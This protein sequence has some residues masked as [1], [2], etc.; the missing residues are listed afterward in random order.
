MK[1]QLKTFGPAFILLAGFSWGIFPAFSRYLY[2]VGVDA[3]TVA[4]MRTY[5]SAIIYLVIALF[6]GTFKGLKWKDIPFFA[7]FGL[8]AITGTY[9]FYLTAMQQLS[10]AMASILLYTAPVFVTI[11]SRIFYKDQITPAALLTLILTLGGCFFVVKGY[12][13]ASLSGNIVGILMG[14]L[15][16]IC[17]STM[18]LFGRYGLHK[19]TQMQNTLLPVIFGAVF[20]LIIRPPWT[21]RMD[22]FAMAASYT[23]VAVLGSVLPVFLYMKGMAMGVPGVQA[24]IMATVEPVVATLMGTIL[25]DP[26]EFL[27]IVGIV[28]TLFGAMLPAILALRKPNR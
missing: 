17:Y 11:F 3:L 7:V 16:A 1:Q 25:G 20:F 15:S 14:V 6:L 8:L 4:A 18:T 26:L 28:V 5:L 24:S 27:Q 21:I 12:D 9:S 10:I 23:G 19:Y 2:S 22:N 13:F